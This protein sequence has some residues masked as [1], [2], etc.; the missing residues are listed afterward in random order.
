MVVTLSVFCVD[1]NESVMKVRFR[2]TACLQAVTP[3]LVVL[4][5]SGHKRGSTALLSE[6]GATALAFAGDASL[7]AVACDLPKQC[8][9]MYSVSTVRAS[10][11]N[12]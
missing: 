3:E 8:L 4:D 6:G 5:A 11:V 9:A 2:D 12:V 1:V 10:Q 7:V